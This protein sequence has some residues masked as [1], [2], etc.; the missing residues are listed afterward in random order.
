MS[1]RTL[2]PLLA[3]V[4]LVASLPARAASVCG[5]TTLPRAWQVGL[6]F[7]V[8]L[9]GN[10]PDWVNSTSAYGVVGSMPVGDDA[11]QL[12][13]QYASGNEFNLYLTEVNYRYL[14]PTPYFR[15]FALAGAHYLHYGLSGQNHDG[16]G[17]NLGIGVLV[18]L[19][20]DLHLS[21]SLKSYVRERSI[22]SVG[23]GFTF[24]L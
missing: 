7:Q 24:L 14:I 10:L 20:R 1:R 9:A 23:G 4:L 15:L 5:D 19:A 8:L 3:A 16:P 11:I 17:G 12:Q 6:T 13:W 2:S 18:P 21:V 22:L